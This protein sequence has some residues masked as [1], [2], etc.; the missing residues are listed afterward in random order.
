MVR[1]FCSGCRKEV[2]G[3]L[4]PSAWQCPRCVK[5]D[6]LILGDN[7]PMFEV[8]PLGH[9]IGLRG[10]V[11]V[12]EKFK[13]TYSGEMIVV[14]AAG[15]LPL[16]ITPEH[17]ICIASLN[18]RNIHAPHLRL[19]NL[20]SQLSWK[21]AGKLTTRN[22]E[23]PL[24]GDYLVLPRIR[25]NNQA[26]E[27]DVMAYTTPRG[28]WVCSVKNLPTIFPLTEETAWLLGVY[29]AEGYT[30]GKELVF[31]LNKKG[32]HLASRI[33]QAIKNL[34]YKARIYDTPTALC[35]ALQSR[36]LAR[37][38]AA[39]CGRGAA[40]KMI[41]EFILLQTN[42]RIL[43]RFLAGYVEGEGSKIVAK[44]YREIG[45]FDFYK[46]R[47]S[48][49]SRLLSLQ[50]QLAYARL[51]YFLEI[52]HHKCKG[53]QK[54]QGRTVHIND[55]YI[56]TYKPGRSFVRKEHSI[57]FPTYILAPIRRLDRVRYEG[58]VFNVATSDETYL[59]SNAVV[60]NC[61]RI[62]C[63][64]C[65]K[66]RIGLLFKKPVCPECGIELYDASRLKRQWYPG[67]VQY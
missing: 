18:P 35:V 4:R 23:N 40:K 31:A 56:L 41:P 32:T 57:V 24:T 12:T 22:G 38:F 30:G 3:F 36:I 58:E 15:M 6:T 21:D 5:G 45:R 63:D 51:G 48:T 14:K 1:G 33:G 62:F 28:R 19:R 46:I 13:R 10:L 49:T 52:F 44:K 20:V 39:W 60:H 66:G 26:A 16:E 27:I 61:R 65:P 8:E 50:L 2:G 34:G 55:R 9:C 53:T 67:P 42:M 43:E 7:K 11:T 64:R 47:A 54:I 59:V 37:A 17:P 25:G 29:V